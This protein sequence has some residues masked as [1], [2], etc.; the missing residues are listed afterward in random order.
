MRA[1]LAPLGALILLSAGCGAQ[2]VPS[3]ESGRK[4]VR[5]ESLTRYTAA[6]TDTHEVRST[7]TY[8]YGS[9][10]SEYVDPASGCRTIT[11]G[12]QSYTEVPEAVGVPGGKRWVRYDGTGYDVEAE[13]EKTLHDQTRT[14]SDGMVVSESSMILFASAGPGPE[15]YLDYLR[16]SS[17]AELELVGE[18]EI[19][20]E[21][22]THY[23]GGVDVRS[24][25]RKELE[26]DGWK[27]AN[28]DRYLAQ[29]VDNNEVVDV[30]V[31]E[32]GLV[33]RV[34]TTTRSPAGY[35]SFE[36]VTT[37]DYVDYGLEANIQAP[38][39]A[40]VLDHTVWQGKALESNV[41]PTCLH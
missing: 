30:W 5:I 34:V 8:D 14:T 2:T 23:R 3:D 24:R 1:R 6:G 19:R 31:G 32:D 4:T 13:F 7:T 18:E 16:A 39:A 22:T 25:T 40:D 11:I 10:R 33:R 26:A 37:A 15:Q 9:G 36:S 21:Q 27:Q 28:I 38:P 41:A 29:I 20:G 35:P 12:N 17:R